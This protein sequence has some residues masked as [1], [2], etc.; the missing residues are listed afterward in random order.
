MKQLAT[1]DLAYVIKRLPK[2]VLTLLK[3]YPE[4]LSVGGGFIRCCITGDQIKDIDLFVSNETLAKEV[5]DKLEESYKRLVIKSKNAYTVLRPDGKPPVQIIFRWTYKKPEDVIFDLDFSICCAV[6]WASKKFQNPLKS[7][8][9]DSYYP[10]LAAKRLRYTQPDRNEDAGG[11][12]L[13]V[14]KYYNKGYKITL[15]SYGKVIARCCMGVDGLSFD[16]WRDDVEHHD[17]SWTKEDQLGKV[18]T[19]LLVEVDPNTVRESND[20]FEEDKEEDND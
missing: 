3:T 12:L 4:E 6:I 16:S 19:G 10:D 7:A 9:I 5:A 20:F 11:T 15:D 13:R 2:R 1:E 8:C 14:L 18:L 17:D